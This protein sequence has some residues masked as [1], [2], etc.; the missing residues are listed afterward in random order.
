MLDTRTDRLE[1]LRSRVKVAERE[2][3]AA[4]TEVTMLARQ[5][6]QF[7]AQAKAAS[8]ESVRMGSASEVLLRFSDART[9][10]VRE[11]LEGVVSAGLREVFGED[12]RLVM[13]TKV[14]G[15]RTETSLLL[16]T[17]IAG[18]DLETSIMDARGGGVA[19][20]TGILLRVVSI[21]LHGSSRFLVL[22]ESFAQVSENFEPRLA[23]FLSELAGNLGMQILLVTHSNAY[24]DVSDAV[25]RTSL[26]GGRTRLERVK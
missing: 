12:L 4:E 19:A 24:E 2:L 18:E 10:A 13:S 9:A 11:K 15:K 17:E 21:L 7:A 8:E 1:D 14:V 16:R 20:V 22:D 25:Y 6:K 26:E 5:G 23:D 3:L